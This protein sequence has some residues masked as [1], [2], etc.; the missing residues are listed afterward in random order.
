MLLFFAAWLTSEA[1]VPPRLPEPERVIVVV[2][3]TQRAYAL[4]DGLVVHEAHC[5]TGRPARPTPEGTWPVREKR[6]YNRALPEYGGA[7][8]PY[9]LRL[10]VVRNGRRPRIAIHA[11][12]SVPA[13]PSSNG[14]IRLRRPDAQVFFEFAEVGTPVIV[15]RSAPS[16]LVEAQRR[17]LLARAEKKKAP[18]ELDRP[19][20]FD[21]PPPLEPAPRPR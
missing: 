4:R 6:R 15:S 21:R 14:C 1:S 8:I 16:L 5:C 17:T 9:S 12:H 20:D 18:S 3:Q 10:D 2:L 11:Y 19:F 13:R 7:P